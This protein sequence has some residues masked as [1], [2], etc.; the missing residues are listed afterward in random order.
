MT[1]LSRLF[2]GAVLVALATI[3]GDARMLGQAV[4]PARPAPPGAAAS[5]SAQPAVSAPSGTAEQ[6]VLKQYCVTCHNQRLHTAGL[7]LDT[8]DPAHVEEHAA[9]WEKVVNKVRGGVMPPAGRPRP[10]AATYDRLAS[11][12]ETRLDRAAAVAPDPGRTEALHRLNRAEYH[13][14]VR[15]ILGLD[16]DVESLLPSDS[17]S[18]GFDNV[19]GVQRMSPQLLLAYLGA[20]EKISRLALGT[21]VVPIYETFQIREDAGQDERLEGLP[22]GTR[23][24]ALLHYNF[25]ADGD[26]SI[27]VKLVRELGTTVPEFDQPQ[28]LAVSIDG[29]RVTEFTMA[30][31]QPTGPRRDRRTLDADWHVTVPVKAGQR[32]VAIAFT[33]RTPA[34]LET[35]VQPFV[36]PY[37]P[38]G[39][40][41][42]TQKGAYVRDIEIA[43]PFNPRGTGNSTSRQRI[44]VC[45]PT[46]PAQVA[47]CAKT[48][49]S[50][51]ARRAY[52]RP[53]TD[54][55][56]RPLLGFYEEG[57]AAGG[58]DIGIDRALQALLTSADF[59]FR[60]ERDPANIRPNAAYRVSDIELASRLSFFLWSSV[61]DEQLLSLAVAGRLKDP[62]VLDTQVRR[63]LADARAS[64]MVTNFAGQ[65][66]SLRNIQAVTAD[67]NIAPDFDQD[68][69][70]AFRRE[71]ELFFE[72]I[73]REDRSV[74]DLLGANYTFV[75]ERLARQYGI[76][77]IYG[78]HFRRVTLSDERRWGLLG[79][80]SF[81]AVNANPHR[82]SPVLRGKWILSNILGT[83]PPD[84]P[85]NVPDLKDR[86]EPS[87]VAPSM[88]ARMAEH[89]GN[90]VCA[91]C[92]AIMDPPGLAL[93]NFDLTGKWRD[94]D[95]SWQ[96]IDATGT[97]PDGTKF[98][99]VVGLRKALLAR[100]ERFVHTTTE[101]LLTYALGR[102]VEYYDAPAVRRIVRDAAAHNYR[103]S[104]LV[105]GVVRSQPFQMRRAPAEPAER[106]ATTR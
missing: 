6:A 28:T 104:S 56:L 96:P 29:Q 97:L 105:L 64:A 12:L 58:F 26:Y 74:L 85:A 22:F 75:N 20:A 91:S 59:L 71:T 77:N 17:S 18:Y 87:D 72:S 35:F 38:V 99:G 52:R 37:G 19:A 15:D 31:Q 39:G 76:P 51:L 82:T 63:M 9:V 80:G 43:G 60:V 78:T 46:Q 44:L 98:D 7:A 33:N 1:R 13:N 21:A 70:Q 4:A 10:D 89:R 61:P 93:E 67:A 55:D 68:L 66:L 103:F 79:Q 65:W 47:A 86:K 5:T 41:Y 84:P 101:K 23:G 30:A 57:R 16:V 48:I 8:L 54:E 49:L 69:R 34:L 62:A 90:P 14:A 42:S 32:D 100:P 25:P 2:A 45:H 95:E 3:G 36:R 94:V 27:S 73:M 11:F 50:T 92:H 53:V 24:G 81:L 106:V 88:R 83:P 102:G 40:T